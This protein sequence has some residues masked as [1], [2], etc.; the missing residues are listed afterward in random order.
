M[1]SLM[2]HFDQEDPFSLSV[3]A[4]FLIVLEHF[5]LARSK[6]LGILLLHVPIESRTALLGMVA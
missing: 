4:L 2:I 6:L 3:S 1:N 5:L